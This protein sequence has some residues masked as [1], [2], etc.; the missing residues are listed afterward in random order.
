MASKIVTD[1]PKHH[2]YIVVNKLERKKK[3]I[4][5]NF[6]SINKLYDTTVLI[7]EFI[8]DYYYRYFATTCVRTKYR[9]PNYHSHNRINYNNIHPIYH[10]VKDCK[11]V[12]DDC[13]HK[14]YRVIKNGKFIKDIYR[15]RADHLYLA[16]KHFKRT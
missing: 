13:N 15:N 4:N 2:K 5:I 14:T 12:Y 9:T 11:I 10:G 16:S 6:N 3:K 1:D 7:V 8:Y